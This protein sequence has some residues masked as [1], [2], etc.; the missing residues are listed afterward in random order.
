MKQLE[1]KRDLACI[2]MPRRKMTLK[3]DEGHAYCVAFKA[4]FYSRNCLIKIKALLTQPLKQTLSI[5]FF[6]SPLLHSQIIGSL[7]LQNLI[8]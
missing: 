7:Y 1:E 2:I 4:K 3:N 6:I 5:M 8:S